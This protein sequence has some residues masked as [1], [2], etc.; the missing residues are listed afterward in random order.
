MSVGV[1]MTKTL[2]DKTSYL[3]YI[4]RV[5]FQYNMVE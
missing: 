1:N 3:N 5:Q 4:A 2:T